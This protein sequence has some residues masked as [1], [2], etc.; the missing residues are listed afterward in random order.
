MAARPPPNP[1]RDEADG[2]HATPTPMPSRTTPRSPSAQHRR[3]VTA[4]SDMFR[5]CPRE[6]A[7]WILRQCPRHPSDP[8]DITDAHFIEQTKGPRYVVPK[9]APKGAGPPTVEGTMA[10]LLRRSAEEESARGGLKVKVLDFDFEES[11]RQT[12]AEGGCEIELLVRGGKGAS[13]LGVMLPDEHEKGRQTPWEVLRSTSWHALADG[14]LEGVERTGSFRTVPLYL[15]P[16]T[17]LEDPQEECSVLRGPPKV[18]GLIGTL[19]ASHQPSPRELAERRAEN[20]HRLAWHEGLDHERRTAAKRRRARTGRAGVTIRK[21]AALVPDVD[22]ANDRIT[23]SV[24]YEIIRLW[25]ESFDDLLASLPP[26]CIGL[27]M[28]GH[29]PAAVST[30]TA[31]ERCAFTLRRALR[32]EARQRTRYASALAAVATAFVD[33][34]EA[35]R[36]LR[37][38]RLL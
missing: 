14:R 26:A 36:L 10:D 30:A 27:A 37:K 18:P 23:M 5:L 19:L 2:A 17:G 24:Y 9:R 34:E 32:D 21:L 20:Q 28:F 35:T 6:G 12:L 7:D 22:V 1:G 8:A 3:A 31:L 38:M 11:F 15:W 13:M 29:R 4:V 16:D 25:D 33:A